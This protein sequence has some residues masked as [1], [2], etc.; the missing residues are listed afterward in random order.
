MSGLVIRVPWPQAFASNE[1]V[2][3][4]MMADYAR[5]VAIYKA[6][7]TNPKLGINIATNNRRP[8]NAAILRFH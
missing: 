7:R 6:G 5:G 3:K 8:R 1:Q 2:V 4:A